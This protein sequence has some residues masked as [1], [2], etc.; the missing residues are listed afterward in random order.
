MFC[1]LSEL[2]KIFY[3]LNLKFVPINFKENIKVLNCIKVA[4]HNEHL[5]RGCIK[6]NG[7]DILTI[8]NLIYKV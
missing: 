8:K 2:F 4:D 5:K 7:E 6:E 1:R 3:G